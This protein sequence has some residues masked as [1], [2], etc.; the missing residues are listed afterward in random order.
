MNVSRHP[1]SITGKCT[2]LILQLRRIILHII[3]QA[4]ELLMNC[5]AIS[6]QINHWCYLCVKTSAGQIESR[7][8]SFKSGSTIKDNAGLFCSDL[9]LKKQIDKKKNTDKK[10]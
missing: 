10:I 5:K 3:A 7:I 4:D 6:A 1:N 8:T 9:H 2:G